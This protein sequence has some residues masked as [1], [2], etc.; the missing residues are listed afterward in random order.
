MPDNPVFWIL[1][2]IGVAVLAAVIWWLRCKGWKLIKLKFKTDFVEA[3]FEPRKDTK[4]AP[5]PQPPGRSQT[6][7]A[8]GAS[9]RISRASQQQH[10][11]GGQ[12]E[13]H[14]KDGVVENGKQTIQ[15]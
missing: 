13:M 8:N 1:I 11:A 4:Q 5:S 6:M 2:A 15:G 3:E 7:T 14:A 10:G 9:S 12:Q